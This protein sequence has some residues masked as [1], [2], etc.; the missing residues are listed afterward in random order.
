MPDMLE[1][2]LKHLRYA[3]I[4]RDCAAESRNPAARQL[5]MTVASLHETR[6]RALMRRL[7]ARAP[8]P[9]PRDRPG[10]SG[11]PAAPPRA[12]EPVLSAG[13]VSAR[14]RRDR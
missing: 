6:G 2:V 3:M 10:A 5:L 4:L 7:R 8:A 12:D 1:Q 9:Q 11:I 14:T 13:N